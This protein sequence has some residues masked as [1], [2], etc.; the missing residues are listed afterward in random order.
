MWP[1]KSKED[2][3]LEKYCR[4]VYETIEKNK[5]NLKYVTHYRDTH[6]LNLKVN[7]K[8]WIICFS[9]YPLYF[10]EWGTVHVNNISI[11]GKWGEKLKKLLSNIITTKFK[12]NKIQNIGGLFK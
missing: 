10:C 7:S 11:G 4:K 12:Q 2:K 5:N 6:K 3:E 8:C 1:F 9:F